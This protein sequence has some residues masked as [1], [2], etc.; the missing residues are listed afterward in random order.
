MK[1]EETIPRRTPQA[2]ACHSGI[3]HSA[4]FIL[5]FP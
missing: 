5:H 2:A 4:F 1:N 3:L